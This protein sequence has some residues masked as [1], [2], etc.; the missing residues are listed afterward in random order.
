MKIKPEHYAHMKATIRMGWT[1]ETIA[2]RKAELQHDARVKD[3]AKRL[4]WDVLY[5]VVGSRWICDA[6]YPYANDDHIDTALRAIM[7]EVFPE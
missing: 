3:L 5:S 7:R 2:A 1:D 4:R 6:I